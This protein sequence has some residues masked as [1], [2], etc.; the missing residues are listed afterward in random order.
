LPSEAVRYLSVTDVLLI[1]RDT[2]EREGGIEGVRDLGLLE[3]A[4]ATPR[5]QLFGV[6]LHP[7][8]AAKAAAYLFHIAMNHPFYDGNKR[9][10]AMA[11][12]VFL[13]VN[14]ADRLPEPD[15]LE[16]A[17]LG[18][19]AGE[20]PKPELVAWMRRHTGSRA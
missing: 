12:L 15:D 6:E 11:A 20:I 1:H 18:V 17:T 2:L 4:V 5:Q 16:R 10:A 8:L 9:A 14:G 13:D 19:A 3:S 7:G